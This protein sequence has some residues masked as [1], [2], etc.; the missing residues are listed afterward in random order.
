MSRMPGR[1]NNLLNGLVKPDVLVKK[2]LE[3][4]KKKLKRLR[5]RQEMWEEGGIKY[6]D[7][8]SHF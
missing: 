5:N 7:S 4:G 2:M 1:E 3:R 8:V 6:K